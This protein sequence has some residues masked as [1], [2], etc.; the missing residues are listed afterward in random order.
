MED[1]V[2]SA[3]KTEE[4]KLKARYSHLGQK[5]GG[6]GILRKDCRKGKNILIL[7]ITTWPKEK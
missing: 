5:P 1:K 7:G 3:E 4:A 6:S 2:T